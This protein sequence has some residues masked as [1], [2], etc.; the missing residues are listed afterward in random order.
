MIRN[1]NRTAKFNVMISILASIIIFSTVAIFYYYNLSTFSSTASTINEELIINWSKV[2]TSKDY[3]SI[4]SFNKE[5]NKN[6]LTRYATI[7]YIRND[8][9]I[10]YVRF[11]IGYKYGLMYIFNK[12]YNKIW[13]DCNY[14]IVDYLDKNK[15]RINGVSFI[16]PG[17]PLP[18]SN[19]KGAKEIPPNEID[20]IYFMVDPEKTISNDISYIQ[21]KIN[22][23]KYENNEWVLNT[24]VTPPIQI[25]ANME[26]VW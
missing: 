11:Y 20:S 7:I 10:Y 13:I 12:N 21:I 16:V 25:E 1:L 26:N 19:N 22:Y 23:L 4:E 15:N 6:I 8:I 17:C 5:I 2:V 9:E 18:F 3:P 14:A 24:I